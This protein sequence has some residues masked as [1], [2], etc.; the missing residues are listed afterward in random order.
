MKTFFLLILIS[1]TIVCCTPSHFYTYKTQMI[2]PAQSDSLVYE[3]DSLKVK[4]VIQDKFIIFKID[5]KLNEGIK[6][7]WDEVSFSVK[8]FTYRVVHKETG[9]YKIRDAQFSTTIP[10]KSY[11]KDGII[12]VDKL[13]YTNS[14][15][16]PAIKATFPDYDYGNKKTI[17]QI[18][19][20]K[21]AD[22]IIYL[23]IYIA[24]NFVTGS[25]HVKIVDIIPYKAVSKRQ[26]PTL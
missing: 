24:G 18:K 4:F 1:S 13:V 25:Y 16:M 19:K 17:A 20:L 22:V 5:N 7:N 14:T 26:Y 2:S 3:N 8:G 23:P 11:L 21:G 15:T 10:P 9:V 6:I 12:P